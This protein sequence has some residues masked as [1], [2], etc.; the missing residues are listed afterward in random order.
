MAR[1]NRVTPFGELVAVEARGTWMGNRGCLHDDRQRIVRAHVGGRWI[2]CLLAFH[3]RH[4][5]VMSPGRYTELFFLDEPTALAA[6]HRPCAECQRT[7]F[8]LFRDTWAAAN[9]GSARGA[10]PTVAA[11]DEALHHERLTEE[12]AKRTWIARVADLPTGAMA[13]DPSGAAWLVLPSALALWGPSGYVRAVPKPARGE[14]QV[15]TPPSVVRALALGFPVAVHPSVG[16]LG[17]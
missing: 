3:D 14:L 17:H 9:T 4:R 7:R 8:N 10:P 12:G 13:A 6:G 16:D 11:L 1:Q 2:Y 5:E 15:L